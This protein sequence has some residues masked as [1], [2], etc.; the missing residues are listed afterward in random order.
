[1][2]ISSESK[3]S[4]EGGG[5]EDGASKVV[6]ATGDFSP[7]P[8]PASEAVADGGASKAA[9]NVAEDLDCLASVDGGGF[10]FIDAFFSAEK[11]DAD[12]ELP[13]RV[14]SAGVSCD[15]KSDAVNC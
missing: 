8:A 9:L 5:A 4:D 7:R 10:A 14:A 11:D 1:M 6:E 2:T 12:V 3:V 15:T 13:S